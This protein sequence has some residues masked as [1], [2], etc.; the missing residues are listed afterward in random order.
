M[1]IYMDGQRVLPVDEFRQTFLF[2]ARLLSV[3]KGP[4]ELMRSCGKLMLEM[5][6][7]ARRRGH[8]VGGESNSRSAKMLRAFVDCR[9]IS[10]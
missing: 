3:C 5:D 4:R 9:S 6:R 7:L 10:I 1:V 2:Q 8:Q